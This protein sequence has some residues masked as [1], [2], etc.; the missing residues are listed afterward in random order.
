MPTPLPPLAGARLSRRAALAV[1]V[2]A[3]G[4]LAA[5][6]PDGGASTSD[7]GRSSGSASPGPGST[8]AASPEPE[9]T[10]DPDVAV[11]TSA[12]AA[13]RAVL[14]LLAS[15]VERTPALAALLD[16]AR[17]THESHADLL[18]EAVPSPSQGPSS[19]ASPSSSSS[20]SPSSSPSGSPAGPS[21]APPPGPG[22]DRR[23]RG[24][25]A[26]VVRAEQRLAATLGRHALEAES[27]AFARVLGSMAAA[28][29]Q[30][31]AQLTA[32]NGRAR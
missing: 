2:G 10:V 28:S 32:S 31:A 6:T 25:L 22:G 12:L 11:A 29:A 8:G 27:G 5:C 23:T 17:A 7:P 3:V 18:A 26:E 9:P 30:L 15:T 13:Q 19:S 16:P 20:P 21:S 1:A 4:S 24:A 14:E